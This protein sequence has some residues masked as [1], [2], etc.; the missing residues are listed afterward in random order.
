DLL[1]IAAVRVESPAPFAVSNLML[2]T[3]S[4]DAKAPHARIVRVELPGKQRFLHLA[5]VQVF[6]RGE[7]VALKGTA[8]QSSTDFGGDA[9]R[10]IDGNTNGDYNANSVCHTGIED[11]PWWEVNLGKDVPVEKIVLWNRTDGGDGISSRMK[12]YRI[13]LYETGKKQVDERKSDG[14]PNPNSEYSFDGVREVALKAAG[15][16]YV[17]EKPFT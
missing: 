11:N 3:S 9:K 8:K 14:Y 16:V 10:A 6:S 1:S 4:T 13:V 2:S 15:G 12:G 7:N 5:E 17:P